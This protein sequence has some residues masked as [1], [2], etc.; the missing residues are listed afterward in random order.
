M[1]LQRGRNFGRC[2]AGMKY[3]GKLSS[4]PAGRPDAAFGSGEKFKRALE[5]IEPL[6]GYHCTETYLD[7]YPRTK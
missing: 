2:G 4:T 1:V 6:L 7:H 5:R 3:R